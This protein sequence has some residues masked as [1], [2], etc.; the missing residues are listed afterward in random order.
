M[1]VKLLTE[2]H[3]EVLSLKKVG[4]SHPSLYLSKC[5]KISCRGSL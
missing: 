1:I 3:L 5:M 4:E 2:H